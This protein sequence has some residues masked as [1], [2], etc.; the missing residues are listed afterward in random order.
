MEKVDHSNMKLGKL[1]PKFDDRTFKLSNYITPSAL[2]SIPKSYR[3]AKDIKQ[4]G[5]MN[6][7]TIGCCT[8]AAAGHAQMEWTDDN[9]SLFR[10]TDGQIIEA[11]S[12]I[13]GYDPKTGE[14]DNGA[15]L[16]DVLNY[17]RKDG[18]AGHNIEAYASIEPSNHTQVKQGIYL[19]GGA[20]VGVALPI[21]AQ[22]QSIWR[23][24]SGSGSKPNSWGGHCL[25]VVGF[26]V[27]YISF[28]SWGKL[29]KMTWGFWNKYV[30]ESFAVLSTDFISKSTAPNGFN[31]LQLQADLKAL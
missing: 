5:M 15:V 29:M 31:L 3:Y 24:V 4:W 9:G 19:F 1:Q 17:W 12:A 22:T 21:S 7:D 27:S 16:L 18:I 13:T 6:N 2:P 8:I 20:Y 26:S 10:P 28:I 23:V 30:D 25:F 14:N 11:Y